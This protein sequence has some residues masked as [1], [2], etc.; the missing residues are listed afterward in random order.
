MNIQKN[1]IIMLLLTGVLLTTALY[2]SVLASNGVQGVSIAEA[3]DAALSK[4]PG[5][6]AVRAQRDA[7]EAR[8]WE[9]KSGFF[10]QVRLSS[11]FT[12]YSDPSIIVPIHE[13]GVFP[14]LDND[15]F[16]T[17][18]QISVP[19]FSGGRTRAATGAAKASAR[20]S[21]A[22][23]D[24]TELRLIQAVTQIYVQSQEL[25]D[26]KALVIARLN[27]LQQRHREL[28]QLLKEGRISPAERAL[29]DSN[30]ESV[31]SDSIAIESGFF[32]LSVRLAQ[33]LGMNEPIR[34]IEAAEDSSNTAGADLDLLALPDD[35]FGPEV[36]KAQAQL[37]RTQAQLSQATRTFWPEI[38]GFASYMWRSGGELDMT[39]EW[40][41]GITIS[42]PLFE[43]GR[44]IAGVQAAKATMKAAEEQ[45]QSVRQ[46]QSAALQISRNLWQSSKMK[47]EYLKQAVQSKSRSVTAQ[48]Q[49]YESGRISLSELQTQETELL[50]LQGNER[51]AAYSTLLAGLEFHATAGSLS[52]DLAE[53]IVRN[54]P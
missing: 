16:E 7:T 46:A 2:H 4:N 11:G 52:K 54:I 36:R 10:P 42:L 12:R 25:Q 44:R 9:V 1:K 21:A 33:L 43:G 35:Q 32:E 13:Q 29:V 50:Q 28:S 34:P 31:R 14:P 45:A 37:A 22:Q 53:K 26:K 18:A 15:I 5:I 23:E 38:N 6:R 51:S 47:Q 30:I 3:L 49:L 40:A 39:G 8:V 17:V 27:V 41:A 48:K 20:E 24:L 19:L